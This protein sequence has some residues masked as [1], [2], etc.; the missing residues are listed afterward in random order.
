M[1]FNVSILLVTLLG[2]NK[3]AENSVTDS[4][5]SEHQHEEEHDHHHAEGKQLDPFEVTGTIID[6]EG[7]PLSDATVMVGGRADTMVTTSSDGTFSLWFPGSTQG[8]PAIVG[9]KDGY[10]AQGFEFFKPDTPITIKLRKINPP[11]NT[12]Y[13]YMDPGSGFDHMKEDCSHCHTSFSL[14]FISSGH[15]EATKNPLLQ[16]LYAGVTNLHSTPEECEEAGGKW[17]MGIKPGD[18][19]QNIEKCYIGGVLS[20][21]NENCGGEGQNQCDAS[22]LQESERPTH[23]GACADCHAPGIDG[24]AGDRNLHEAIGFAYEYGVHCDTC[25]KVKDID[26]S[27]PPGVGKR[28]VM[29]RPSEPG[30]NVFEWDPVY[31]GPLIDVPN[32]AMGGSY[33]PKFNES[34]FCAGCHEQNQLAL[35]PNETL[36]SNKWPD[37]LPVHSTFSE[38]ED[39]PYNQ[40]ATQ[41]QFC[42]MP[43]NMD[44]MNSVD[45]ANPTN[46]SIT[47]G[48]PR[49][50][51]NI[52]EHLFRGPL[53]G[54]E[55]LID[56][57]LYVSISTTQHSNNLDVSISVSNVGCGHAVPTGEPLR[58]L[59]LVVEADSECGTL[60]PIDGMTINDIGGARAIGIEG[61]DTTTTAQTISWPQVTD[62]AQATQVIRVVRPTGQYDDYPGVGHFAQQSLSPE[63]KGMEIL[64]P[65]GTATIVSNNQGDI[66]LDKQLS[67]EPGDIIYLSDPWPEQP[68]DGQPSLHLAGLPGNSFARVM[69]DSQ[70]NRNVPH[71][72]AIDMA[73]DNRIPPATNAL[74]QHTFEIP[75]DCDSG[76]ISATIIYRQKPLNLSLERGWQTADFIVAK[77]TIE[78]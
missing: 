74:S 61:E 32:V 33:Q 21:I 66:L 35:L 15:I 47:F 53:S 3:A 60:K 37:G 62:M 13:T 17:E 12:E 31:Y 43:A 7:N 50:P 63:E 54:P 29:G 48:F 36:D 65:V 19:E 41:C 51:E 24:I 45:L 10:R 20:D 4:S 67:I 18:P 57:A 73:S 64:A 14:D 72:K 28:L 69:V 44:K 56:E 75:E 71:Y 52:R 16:D 78:W 30:R 58:S 2:C 23:F 39:G 9:A 49:E 46:Q 6:D 42:H 34:Q 70:G 22:N 40:D 68:F 25:H 1:K 26:L 8:E 55:R 59:L 5:H 77:E 11:D 27:Q 76:D 38:W